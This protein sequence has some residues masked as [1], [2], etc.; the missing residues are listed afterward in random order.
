M[1]RIDYEASLESP[2]V[3]VVLPCFRARTT[4]GQVLRRIGPEVAIIVLVDDGCPDQSGARVLE[5]IDDPRL[6]VVHNPTNLGV[7]GAMKRG[8]QEALERG[9]DIVVKIDADGQMDPQHIPRLIAPLIA[10]KADYT[11]ANRFAPAGRMPPGSDPRALAAM[12]ASRRMAN[13]L[14][15]LLH[16]GATGYWTIGD[17]ANGYTAITSP[18][19]AR[20]GLDALADCFFFETDMLYRLNR[21]RARVVEVPLPAI[22]PGSG[23]TLSLRKVAPRFAR[24]IVGRTL[25]RIG[26]ACVAALSARTP[27][28]AG[29][30]RASAPG[31]ETCPPS[32]SQSC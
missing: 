11:K 6:L 13:H 25:Q 1:A 29:R 20:L 24:L 23:T 28:S 9:A 31:P 18:A 7:G 16:R 8:Y 4:V 5:E 22:Y 15:S 17:P 30:S 27:R 10:R 19:L 14:L 3:A 12:P 21:I 32:P 26:G 2:V